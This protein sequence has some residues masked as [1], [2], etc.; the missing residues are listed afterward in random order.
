MSKTNKL[1]KRDV[2]AVVPIK[3]PPVR[4]QKGRNEII[5]SGSSNE[6]IT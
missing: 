6:N 2:P 3:A 5:E 4:K 1:T